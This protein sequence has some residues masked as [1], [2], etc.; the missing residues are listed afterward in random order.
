[1]TKE[2]IFE[3]KKKDILDTLE[4]FRTETENCQDLNWLGAK[5]HQII[6]IFSVE[7]DAV[8][9]VDEFLRLQRKIL[10]N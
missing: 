1:M 10:G 6:M 7:L 2:E 3:I 8:G 5:L 4:Q 9:N